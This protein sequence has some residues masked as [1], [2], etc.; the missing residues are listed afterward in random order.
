MGQCWGV[1]TGTRGE[2]EQLGGDSKMYCFDLDYNEGL[3]EWPD[4]V[5]SV[6]SLKCGNWMQFINEGE[7]ETVKAAEIA[8]IKDTVWC[9][10][11]VLSTSQQCT[12]SCSWHTM[13]LNVALPKV[14]VLSDYVTHQ[15]R[16]I[17][18]TRSSAWL[19]RVRL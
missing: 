7:S 8:A 16:S 11:I 14:L 9:F 18:H 3:D 5:F 13:S 6:D 1:Y 4:D 2:A 15:Q 10:S 17:A 19:E 12:S